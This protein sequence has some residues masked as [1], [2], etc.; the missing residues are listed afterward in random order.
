M[1]SDTLTI[2]VVNVQQ[3]SRFCR[4]GKMNYFDGL[5]DEIAIYD[6]ALGNTEI[7]AIYDA[8]SA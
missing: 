2:G 4:A 8:G 1:D 6:G 3:G 5:M 7:K